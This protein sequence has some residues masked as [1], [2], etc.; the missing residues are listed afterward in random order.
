[1][2]TPYI[3]TSQDSERVRERLKSRGVRLGVDFVLRHRSKSYVNGKLFLEYINIIFIPYL[4]EL[5]Q[6]EEFAECEAVL[7]MDSCSPHMGEAVIALLA[8]ALV[9]TFAPHTTQIFQ[10]LDVVLC[11]ALKKTC[12]ESHYA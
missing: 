9:V 8:S 6:S 5:Q 7:L 10:V 4:N 3:V 2:L 12:Y 11:D 1:L